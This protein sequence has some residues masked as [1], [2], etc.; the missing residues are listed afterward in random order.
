M[1]GVVEM[2]AIGAVTSALV[3]VAVGRRLRGVGVLAVG[4]GLLFLGWGDV[5]WRLVVAYV[6]GTT[7]GPW[8]ATNLRLLGEVLGWGANDLVRPRR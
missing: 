6:Q 8:S 5:Q 2:M 4:M 1:L 7:P 3:T